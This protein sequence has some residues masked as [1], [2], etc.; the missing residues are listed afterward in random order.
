MAKRED[1]ANSQVYSLD[2]SNCSTCVTQMN[3]SGTVVIPTN[4]GST[5]TFVH[6]VTHAIQYEN[7][8]MAFYMGSSNSLNS[9]SNEIEA[10]KNQAAYGGLKGLNGI[11]PSV[12]ILTNSSQINKAFIQGI[13]SGGRPAYSNLA[14][15]PVSPGLRGSSIVK[16]YPQMSAWGI[17]PNET[18]RS[19]MSG[20]TG[21]NAIKWRH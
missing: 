20:A 8:Q 11:N 1:P 13:Q 17:K 3:S 9:F 19:V 12:P 5:E 18:L 2:N 15:T 10:Y 14:Q 7:N 6:E 4:G 16:A 21:G